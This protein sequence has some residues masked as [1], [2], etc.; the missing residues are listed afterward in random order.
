M[1]DLPQ[2]RTCTDGRKHAYE[3][4]DAVFNGWNNPASAAELA[5][6]KRAAKLIFGYRDI[7]GGY[8]WAAL[9]R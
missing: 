1:S 6:R 3:L 7:T 8:P 5:Y 4:E 2:H 9:G